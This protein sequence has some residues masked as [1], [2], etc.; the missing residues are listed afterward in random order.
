VL[1]QK[2]RFTIEQLRSIVYRLVEE[3]YWDL[4]DLLMLEM[5]AEGEVGVGKLLLI[6]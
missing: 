2:V 1:C 3:T 6:D 4:I 5:N